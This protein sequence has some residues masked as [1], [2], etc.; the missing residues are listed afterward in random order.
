MR[1]VSSA[2]LV[3][4]F[5]EHSDSVLTEPIVITRNGRDRLVIMDVERYREIA[6][7]VMR[8]APEPEQSADLNALSARQCGRGAR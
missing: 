8:A 1:R 2:D 6:A 3:R 7:A 5:S 4:N